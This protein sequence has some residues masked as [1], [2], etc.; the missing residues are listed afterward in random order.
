MQF[1]PYAEESGLI[2]HLGKW[3]LREACRQNE[4]WRCNGF[5]ALRMAVNVSGRQFRQHDFVN[6]VPSIL[7]ETGMMPE[8][9]ELDLTETVFMH[10]AEHSASAFGKLR[11]VGVQLAISDF[12]IGYSNL[13]YLKRFGVDR[14][15]IDQ[16]F[17]RDITTDNTAAAIVGAIT[18]MARSLKIEVTAAGVETEQQFIYLREH[19]CS[20]VQGF[21]FSRPVSAAEFEQQLKVER[22]GAFARRL[23]VAASQCRPLM[24]YANCRQL[25]VRWRSV[26]KPRTACSVPRSDAW[27]ASRTSLA[28]WHA[29]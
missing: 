5:P 3:I 2:V 28:S 17:V 10:E 16:S 9:L 12:G 14:L 11:K 18:A 21:L 19:G 1:I 15:K 22:S 27:T 8:T 20:E 23:P 26:T 4:A 29:R 7:S 6:S 24:A 25:P 13:S